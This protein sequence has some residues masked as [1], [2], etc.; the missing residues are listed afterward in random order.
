MR[1]LNVVFLAALLL[2]PPPPN[3]VGGGGVDAASAG[4]VEY[5]EVAHVKEGTGHDASNADALH[6]H[7]ANRV[8]IE[9][10]SG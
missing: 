1:A 7:A 9:Y 5:D 8:H 10:C 4:G 3:S 6:T 2:A